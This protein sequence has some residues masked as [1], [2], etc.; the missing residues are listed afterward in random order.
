[1]S[2]PPNGLI[3]LTNTKSKS[4]FENH[5]LKN[6]VTCHLWQ[7][8]L[9]LLLHFLLAGKVLATARIQI[10]VERIKCCMRPPFSRKSG[11]DLRGRE[12]LVSLNVFYRFWPSF[13]IL[14]IYCQLSCSCH[15]GLKFPALFDR[16]AF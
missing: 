5:S 11:S 15:A 8:S 2:G 9:E 1:M 13:S 6:E 12:G 4:S 3:S 7:I 10:E 16:S 14:K